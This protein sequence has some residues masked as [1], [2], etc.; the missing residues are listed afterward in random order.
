MGTKTVLTLKDFERLPEDGTLHELS[1]GELISV[2]RPRIRHM[3][4]A[5][6]LHESLLDYVRP[7]RLGRVFL[8][9][10]FLLAKD[11]PT[12]R[13]PDVSFVSQERT[14]RWEIDGWVDGAPELAVEVVSPSETARDLEKKVRQYLAAG[15]QLVWVIYPETQTIHVFGPD[16]SVRI[17][18][19]TDT[20][21]APDLFPGWSV[22]VSDLLAAG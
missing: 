12:L 2:T 14:S 4:A 6:N 22:P 10:N 15:S 17:L 11:P 5:A 21:D 9:G 8:E 1:E 18:T 20:L 13:V 3:L 7:R 19:E 16:L